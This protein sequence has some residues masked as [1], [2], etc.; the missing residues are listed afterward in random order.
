MLKDKKKW[1]LKTEIKSMTIVLFLA[2]LFR[3]FVVSPFYIPSGSMI[4]TLLVG[5]YIFATKFTYGFSRYSVPFGGYLFDNISWLSGKFCR[6]Q[7][8]KTG[9]IV[10]FRSTTD[11]DIDFIK[12]VIG[13]PGDKVQMRQGI[14]Y[15]NGQKCQLR[16]IG[17]L[18]SIDMAGNKLDGMMYEEEMPDKS[19]HKVL[20]TKPFGESDGDD[21][22]EY[23]VPPGHYFV[24]GDC[25]DNSND[26]RFQQAITFVPED[27][28]IAK[29][30][31]IFFSTPASIWNP[32]RWLSELR[33]GRLF[34]WTI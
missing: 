14:L 15:L 21:T 11:R 9:D 16:E 20:K 33:L 12:R 23:V 3:S 4:P 27:N 32:I 18:S 26:S 6:V 10:I 24:M 8:P 30:H 19:R 28:I 29:A 1:S 31:V 25:R 2:V 34:Q 5:D 22:E 13:V 7:R 17:P